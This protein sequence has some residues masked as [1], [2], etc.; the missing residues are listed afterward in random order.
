MTAPSLAL[1]I[2]TRD[3]SARIRRCL[4][5]LPAAELRRHA[6]EVIVVD[7]ASHDE[8]P[9]VLAAFARDAG[10]SFQPLRE[11]RPGK[12]HA[13]NTGLAHCRADIIAFTDDDCLLADDYVHAVLRNFADAG[14]HF[15]GGR[16][17]PYDEHD[18]DI[19]MNRSIQRRIFPP[20]SFLAPGI[21]Q[22]G[23]LVI[24]R[25]V[26]ERVGSFDTALGPDTRYRC[27]DI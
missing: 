25:E 6:V 11:N 15:A 1:I 8:T 9:Q 10:F 22:G 20:G 24:R 27:E 13:L 21:F 19:G 3:R 16:Q 17:L 12:S 7:N 23:N 4:S 5:E 14:I 26:F 18:A 2:C